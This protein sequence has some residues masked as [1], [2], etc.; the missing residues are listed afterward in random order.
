MDDGLPGVSHVCDDPVCQDQQDEV[1]L[2]SEVRWQ[3]GEKND[4]TL[5]VRYLYLGSLLAERPQQRGQ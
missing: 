2:E 3:V 1:L 5:F 4:N